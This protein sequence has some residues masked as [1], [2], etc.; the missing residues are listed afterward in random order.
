[1]LIPNQIN[2]NQQQQT[3]QEYPPMVVNA[4]SGVKQHYLVPFLT[5]SDK[6]MSTNTCQHMYHM[7]PPQQQAL[8]QLQQ[9]CTAS[10]AGMILQ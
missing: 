4:S 8:Q 1:M 7:L 10:Q 5:F 2:F 3:I 9:Q 6:N